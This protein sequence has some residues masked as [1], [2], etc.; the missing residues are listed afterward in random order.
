MSIKNSDKAN[1]LLRG[2]G[3]PVRLVPD[4]PVSSL[5]SVH[6]SFTALVPRSFYPNLIH[7]ILFHALVPRSFYPKFHTNCVRCSRPPLYLLEISN[8]KREGRGASYHLEGCNPIN[9]KEFG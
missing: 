7:H 9:T 3:R 5:P 4:E 1:R 6:I 8:E 2:V